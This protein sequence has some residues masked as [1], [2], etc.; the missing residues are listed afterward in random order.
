MVSG[1]NLYVKLLG[2][3]SQKITRR[4]RRAII[5]KTAGAYGTAPAVDQNYGLSPFLSVTRTG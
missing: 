2:G 4:I 5:D 1:F 3:F